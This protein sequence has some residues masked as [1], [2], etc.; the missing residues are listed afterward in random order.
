MQWLLPIAFWNP[1]P[2]SCHS[3]SPAVMRQLELWACPEACAH[4]GTA[5]FIGAPIFF[6]SQNY[7]A[8]S[9]PIGAKLKAPVGKN[10]CGRNRMQSVALDLISEQSA[11]GLHHIQC[12]L[13]TFED[14]CPVT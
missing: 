14:Y 9:S 4:A 13:D 7:N 6:A 1:Q 10:E 2:E 5:N 11:A 12:V 3:F 8:N